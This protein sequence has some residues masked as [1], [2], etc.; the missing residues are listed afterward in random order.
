MNSKIKLLIVLLFAAVLLI[1][2]KVT[3]KTKGGA[4]GGVYVS[5]DKGDNW[6][7]I[8]LIYR[9][10]DLVKTFSNVDL[11]AFTMDPLD[12][13]ALY[14]ATHDDGM[15]YTYDSGVGWH[16]TLEDKGRIN[17]VA[18]SPKESCIIYAAIANRVY[19][20]TD[21]NRHWTYQLIESR[22]DP[23]NQITSLVIDN[24]DTSVI[25]A[26]TSGKGLFRS[27]DGGFSLHVVKFFD[28]RIAKVLINPNNSQIIYVAT[29]S[30]GIF[31]TLDEGNNWQ[32]LFSE[33]IKQSY[34][35]LL[36]YRDIILDP[37]V[38]DGLLYACQYGLFRS[39]DGG[40]N[41]QN[42][43]LLTPPSTTAIYSLAINPNN[44]QEIYYGIDTVLYRTVDGGLNWITRSLPTSR[45]AKFLIIDP[46]EPSRLYLGVKQINK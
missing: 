33:E 11:T 26:G 28:D 14:I 16:Q 13:K 7:Q 38:E 30:S 34:D 21:C 24:F 8:V 32:Q 2:C 20:S 43:K 5:L 35:T 46:K 15:F 22:A 9:V 17:S 4:D 45:A 42:I 12:N 18:I 10:S 40:L 19:K 41:W 31:K 25:Y 44:S 6:N 39:I 23:N 29:E 3:V 1:G 27:D 37:T 36:V